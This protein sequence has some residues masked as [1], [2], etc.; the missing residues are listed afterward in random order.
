MSL[1]IK[2]GGD[3]TPVRGLIYLDA[4]TMYKRDFNGR[5][6]QFPVDSGVNISDHFIS[7]NQKFRVE[8]V[9]SDVDVQ[10][11]SDKIEVEGEKPINAK[12]SPR[13]TELVG[14][15]DALQYLPSSVQQFFERSAATATVD[16]ARQSTNP[17]IV[18]LLSELMTGVY[19]NQADNRWRNKMVPCILYEMDGENFVNAHTDLVITNVSFQEDADSGDALFISFDLEKVRFAIVELTD[20]VSS[21]DNMKKKTAPTDNKGTAP[22]NGGKSTD[23]RDD[24]KD[25]SMPKTAREAW[26]L[27]EANKQ[28]RRGE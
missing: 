18:G 26:E 10:G 7:S 17:T 3:K 21:K 15:T 14:Q 9:I 13:A 19:Y 20:M 11:V 25:S 4:T 5:A 22:E 23:K 1:A 24:T 16:G 27:R 8:G 2:I 12:S 6:T 28:K